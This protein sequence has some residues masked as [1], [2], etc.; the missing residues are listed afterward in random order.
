LAESET[1]LIRRH[2]DR[3]SLAGGKAEARLSESG[4]PVW[5]VIGAWRLAGQDAAQAAADYQLTP[6]AVRAALAFCAKHHTVIDARLTLDA[7]YFA[8]VR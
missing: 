1:E 3:E 8:S 4:V 7:D 5:A 2:I 6:E